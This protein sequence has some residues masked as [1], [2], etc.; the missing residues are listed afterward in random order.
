[1]A[2][3]PHRTWTHTTRT[4]CASVAGLLAALVPLAPPAGASTPP[5]YLVCAFDGTFDVSPGMALVPA[6]QRFESTIRM[7]ACTSSDPALRSGVGA[8]VGTAVGSCLLVSGR[9]Q[10]HITW[11]TGRTSTFEGSFANVL[12]LEP[13]VERGIDGQFAGLEGFNANVALTDPAEGARC[14]GDGLRHATFSGLLVL[15]TPPAGVLR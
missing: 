2:H 7:T 6:A 5:D 1:M 3:R 8:T 9:A 4:L 14:L 11:N 15:G 10:Q 12:V 13:V